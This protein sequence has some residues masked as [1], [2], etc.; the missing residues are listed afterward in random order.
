MSNIIIF[1]TA[2]NINLPSGPMVLNI[3]GPENSLP[4][5]KQA[6]FSITRFFVMMLACWSIGV[7][8]SRD[9]GSQIADFGLNKFGLILFHIKNPKSRI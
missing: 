6:K 8:E 3:W 1:V 5:R 2:D 7:L 9:F 4:K